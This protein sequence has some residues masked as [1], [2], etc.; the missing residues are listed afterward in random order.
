[1]AILGAVS[2]FILV[3]HKIYSFSF[4]ENPYFGIAE[5][6]RNSYMETDSTIIWFLSVGF[7][8][9][10]AGSLM[11]LLPLIRTRRKI[12]EKTVVFHG[13][14]NT[15]LRKSISKVGIPINPH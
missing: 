5:P 2:F 9:A 15:L 13:F 6:H 4:L 14:N 8:L 3:F 1:L 12:K 7:Y 11:L 10:L